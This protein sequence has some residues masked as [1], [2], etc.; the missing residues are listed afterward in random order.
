MPPCLPLSSMRSG[1]WCYSY[2]KGSLRITLD[3][4]HQLCLTTY[5]WR[6]YISNIII[7]RHSWRWNKAGT[8]Y[9][10]FKYELSVWFIQLS[11]YVYHTVRSTSNLSFPQTCLFICTFV[12]INLFMSTVTVVGRENEI[13]AQSAVTV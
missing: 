7:Y 3:E 8:K 5:K 10:I 11:T 6:K 9:H 12:H 4:V 1:S 2:W 13:I